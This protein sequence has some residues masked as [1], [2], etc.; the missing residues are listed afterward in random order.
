[1]VVLSGFGLPV[2]RARTSF[3]VGGFGVLGFAFILTTLDVAGA[4]LPMEC[5]IAFSMHF[6]DDQG[7]ATRTWK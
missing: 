3:F 2:E 6:P 1:M 7:H 5:E 4:F